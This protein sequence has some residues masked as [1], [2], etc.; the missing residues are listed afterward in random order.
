MLAEF[1]TVQLEFRR[2]SQLTGDPKYDIAAT[3]VMDIVQKTQ[4]PGKIKFIKI[5]GLFV[6][7]L[8]PDTLQVGQ[9]N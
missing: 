4:R 6:T 2:L 8:S 1:G 7:F 5:D 9:V 3:K